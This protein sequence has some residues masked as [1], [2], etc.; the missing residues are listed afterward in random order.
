MAIAFF[1][2]VG[3]A[4]GGIAGPLVFAELTGDG[5][6]GRTAL[7]FGTGAIMMIL[8]GVV[9]LILGVRAEGRSL[10]SIATPPSSQSTS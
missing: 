10:E 9:D 6:P 8:G 7:A 5:D 3:T 4:V 2:A 1:Y